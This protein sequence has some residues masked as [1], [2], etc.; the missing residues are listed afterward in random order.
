MS[1]YSGSLGWLILSEGVVEGGGG[2]GRGGDNYA[3]FKVSN[4]KP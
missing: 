3:T 2:G 4:S 1:K